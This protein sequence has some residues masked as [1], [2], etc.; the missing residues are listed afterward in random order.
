MPDA[1][2]TALV[3]LPDA[4]LDYCDCTCFGFSCRSS[5]QIR[6]NQ[7]CSSQL[8]LIPQKTVF[9]ALI[10]YAACLQT[11]GGG[12][13]KRENPHALLTGYENLL[14]HLKSHGALLNA[15]KPELL[16]DITDFRYPDISVLVFT[17]DAALARQLP[18]LFFKQ[19][20][21]AVSC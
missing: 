7:L 18:L 6:Q 11:S 3:D 1:L 17:V 9:A 15:V 8:E 14:A 2:Y 19:V 12:A 10:C 5:H 4:T 21:H 16:L 13:G 20:T